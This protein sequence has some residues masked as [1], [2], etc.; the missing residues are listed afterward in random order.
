MYPIPYN[1]V[2]GIFVKEQVESIRALGV[3]VDVLFINARTGRLRHKAYLGGFPRLWFALR[4]GHY[5]VIHAH[6]VFSEIVAR[7]QW[8]VPVVVTHHGS[9]V[10]HTYQGPLS[11]WM[12][13]WVDEI[14]V[15]SAWM[16][17]ALLAPRAHVIPCGMDL[18]LF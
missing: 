6:Y 1:P 4:R 18:N 11:R 3:E 10:R 5:D 17:D 14:I 7:A 15:Q 16:K 2:F 13:R 12:A 8:Q 9:D